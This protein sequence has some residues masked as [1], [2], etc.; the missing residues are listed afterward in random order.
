MSAQVWLAVWFNVL[1]VLYW[2]TM[3]DRH[4]LILLIWFSNEWLLWIG[5]FGCIRHIQHVWDDYQ[6]ND[7]CELVL[8]SENQTKELSVFWIPNKWLHESFLF[9][10]SKTYRVRNVVRFSNE[11]ILWAGSFLVNHERTSYSL[12]PLLWVGSVMSRLFLVNQTP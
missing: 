9:S 7:F 6:K 5:P 4:Q 10:E 8:F 12:I 2:Q 11:L 3:V 1:M